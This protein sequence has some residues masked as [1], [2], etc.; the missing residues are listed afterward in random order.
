[1]KNALL[2]LLVFIAI[3]CDTQEQEPYQKFEGIAFGTSFHITFRGQEGVINE[4]SI[5][6]IIHRVNKSLSTYISNSDIS[7]INRGDTTVI[8]D[9]QF[10][11][12]FEKSSIIYEETEGF[13]DPTIGT[14]VNAWGFGPGEQIKEM[15]QSTIDSL[16]QYVGFEKVQILNDQLVKKYPETFLD[17]N[18]NAK[19]YGVDRIGRYLEEK[20]ISNYLVEIGGEIRARGVNS[21]GLIWRV[22]IEKPNFD[23]T[24]SFQTIVTLDN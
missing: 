22:A 23:G 11:E 3:S 7:R 19:G 14:M 18:A 21:R 8:I 4:K 5:D 6:S 12:V 2:F 24:R 17:F 16:M 1:M 10:R 20:N 9:D 15:N 13:F